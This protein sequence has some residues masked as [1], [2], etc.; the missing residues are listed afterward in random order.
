MKEKLSRWLLPSFMLISGITLLVVGVP[1]FMHELML[2]PGT[3]I[4]H[5]L[6]AG[7]TITEEEWHTLEQSR[8]DA[9]DFIELPDAYSD[10]GASYLRRTKSAKSREEQV[11]Y[12]EMTVE[13]AMKGLNMAP[14]NTYSWLR[15]CSANLILGPDHHEEA[16]QAWRQS[17]AAAKFE[18]FLLI[19]RV[20][21]GILLYQQMADED[22]EKLKDQLDMAYQNNK[23]KLRQYI[24]E[25]NLIV[26]MSILSEPNSEMKEY[27]V[28]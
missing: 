14:L 25:N 11:K 10:L 20:H 26:W 15:V 7:E 6:N 1:R 17:I 16:L 18:P 22:V 5:R 21:H 9:L 12:A 13:V 2:I 27:L 8:L 28:G 23:W 3:P 19:S 4:L 24:R